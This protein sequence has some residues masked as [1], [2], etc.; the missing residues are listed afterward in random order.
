MLLYINFLA[1]KRFS[2]LLL[3]LG[4][5]S[6]GILVHTDYDRDINL[7]PYT[8]YSWIESNTSENQNPLYYNEL[9][10]KRIK[11][12]V[13]IEMTKKGYTMTSTQPDLILHYH[14]V[15][16]S[17]SELRTDPYGYYGP[18]WLRPSVNTFQ[19]NEGTIIIDIIEA[20]SNALAWR[21]WA[22]SIIDTDRN[23][24]EE[25]IKEALH[26]IFKAYP[27]KVYVKK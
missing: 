23:L 14:L 21:G 10:D 1:M 13:N 16:E 20:K 15:V 6:Q 22:T 12:T 18:Y 3:L 4:G 25:L 9:N 8:T 17:K 7:K 11:S 5:C 2:I 24:K 19:Y 27:H 26:E